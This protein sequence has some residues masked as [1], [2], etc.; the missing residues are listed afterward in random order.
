MKKKIF[1]SQPMSGR[2]DECIKA[3]RAEIEMLAKARFGA[4]AEIIDSFFEGAPHDAKPLWY[5]GK[6]FEKLSEADVAIFAEG[7]YHARGCVMEYEA[8]R[9]YGIETI[10]L[11]YGYIGPGKECEE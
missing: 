10:D 1:I 8:C 4:D 3:E 11:T 7:W 9:N 5:L 2:T 6:A